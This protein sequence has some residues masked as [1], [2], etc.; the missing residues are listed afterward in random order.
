[1][2]SKAPTT[3]DIILFDAGS[4]DLKRAHESYASERRG[5]ATAHSLSLS[6][7]L[8]DLTF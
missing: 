8:S 6:L 1:M 5:P 4:G 7:S 3:A 2:T